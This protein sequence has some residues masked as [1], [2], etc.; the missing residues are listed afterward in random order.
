MQFWIKYRI[1]CLKLKIN[2]TSANSWSRIKDSFTARLYVQMPVMHQSICTSKAGVSTLD[3]SR[4]N[5]KNKDKNLIYQTKIKTLKQYASSNSVHQNSKICLSK[6]QK[7]LFFM[8]CC[9][10]SKTRFLLEINWIFSVSL[11]LKIMESVGWVILWINQIF[12][13]F[14]SNDNWKSKG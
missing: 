2:G 5:I 14:N 12:I 3:I 7:N 1:I 13:I 9:K 4:Q 6:V 11:L 10:I 8:T